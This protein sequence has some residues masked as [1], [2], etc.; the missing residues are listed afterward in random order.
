MVIPEYIT[1][2][3][4]AG[5]PVAYL[6]P[7]AD[8]LKDTWIDAQLNSFCTLTFA[9]PM[10]SGKW[11]ELTDANRIVAGGREFVITKP[12]AIEVSR[13]GQKLW[14]KVMAQES[15]ILLNKKYPTVS[16][17][18]GDPSPAWGTVK[19]LS[20]GT[21]FAGCT[22]GSAKSALSYLFQGSGWTV[23][24]VDV[25]GTH[26]LET[27][28]EHLLANVNKVQELWGGFLV[29]DSLN[30]VV[31]LR[32][33]S[34]WQNYTGFQIRYAKS[35]KNITRTVDYD[36][37][38]RL[39][40]FGEDDLNIGSVNGGVI[41]L[42]NFQYTAEIKEG[43]YRN[44]NIASAQELKDKATEV[45]AKLSKPRY[46]YRVGLVDLR[47]LP[48]YQHEDFTL[49]D[50]VDVIDEGLEINVQVRVFRHKYNVFQ[51]WLCELE[52]GDPI[53]SLAAMLAD[54]KKA[55]EF[56][57]EALKPNAG[58]GNLLKGFVSTFATTINSANGKLV[59]DDST[60]QAIEIDGN[61]NP[62]G[63][64]VRITPGGVG[65]S[66]DGGQTFVTAMTGAGILAN[67]VIVNALYALSTADG[68]TKL[69]ADGLHVFDESAME[70]LIAGWWM[71]GATKRFG[72]KVK[73]ADGATTLLDDQGLL[74][75]WQEGRADN[76]DASNPLVLNIY[77]PPE[78]KSI[79]KALLR[80]RLQAF[81]AYETGAASGG[82]STQTSSS[83]GN[84]SPTTS[85]GGGTTQT[86][87]TSALWNLYA[88]NVIDAVSYAGQHAHGGATGTY[89]LH[90]H[91]ITG[92]TS[93][94]VSGGG[95]VTFVESGDHW[96]AISTEY[97]HS[98][99]LT[100]DHRHDVTIPDHTHAVAVPGHTHDVAIP[101]HA[102]GIIYGIY[103]S[104]AAT[105][106]TVKINGTDRTAAL[107][108]PFNSDQVN[109]NL[110]SYLTIGQWNVIELGSSQ[111][112]R[113]DASVFIQSKMGV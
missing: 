82:G 57:K 89:G 27:D 63:K 83:G 54:T 75:T 113:I 30:K 109:I 43:I 64:R 98:H 18:P 94:A 34:A 10:T 100:A 69:M 45:L 70:R 2:R 101:S 22:A 76:V 15:W 102:H 74:Q 29:W 41:Y 33:E 37:I 5:A 73:A 66:T 49:G 67:T 86:S 99:N 31:H 47:T 11:A 78:T 9:L 97:N 65:I 62:T 60:L 56:V 59:W 36:I 42:N 51:P 6:S 103:T 21:P 111:L 61:G 7:E 28:K 104:T 53:E 13:N 107:G 44:Q 8:G 105:G 19:I 88:I 23:G 91:G 4:A 39:Y 79:H 12:D 14:G 84:S 77:L 95:S 16:N 48:E 26:D 96:H 92:G 1:V 80:F 106:V 24:T 85:N 32:S 112:G 40:P 108:G 35:L 20:G 46:N 25:T 38:T 68:F 17:D 55:S 90:N 3:T 50:M 87:A 58:I 93:L 52:V 71:D 110:A 72:L 81:R